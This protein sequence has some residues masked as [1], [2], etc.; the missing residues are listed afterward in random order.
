MKKYVLVGTGVRGIA[1]YIRPLIKDYTDCADLSAVYD[2]NEKR[3]HAAVKMEN[4]QNVKVYTDFDEMIK[5]EKPDTVII[6]TKDCTHD[7]YAIRAMELGCDVI[8][9]KPLTTDEN[10]FD[11]IY[12]CMKRTGKNVTVTFNMRFHPLY[13]FAKELMMKNVVGRVLSVHFEW[14]L[15][16]K[17]G[18][19]YFRRW[20][21]NRE[22][23]GSLIIHKATH[24]FDIINWLL[25]QHPVKVNA[26]GL[27]G[28]YGQENGGFD[29]VR[30][31]ECPK[32]DSC[33]YFFDI[34]NGEEHFRNLYKN[35]ESEDGYFR[36]R[37][38]FSE[39][40]DIE[41]TM[42]VN[43][44]YE[45][46]TVCSYSLTAHSPYEGNKFAL[47]GTDGRMEVTSMYNQ[48]IKKHEMY[49]KIFHRDGT[50]TT[51]T[52]FTRKTGEKD[53]EGGHGGADA[54]M[55]NMIFRGYRE[56]NLCQIA[57]VEDAAM[58]IGI[59]IAANKSLQQDRAV[60]IKDL[61][62]FTK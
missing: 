51:Y 16:T 54:E 41:D 28:F 26:F 42:S 1:S 2:I 57:G 45:K 14:M 17:H 55:R 7:F 44:L 33:K 29:G 8:S 4:A 58:S 60:Y 5:T 19:D 32:K 61:F 47:N 62:G 13:S 22:N 31:C 21:R 24:H 27:R 25:D 15:D 50:V 11:N 53:F 23:S 37:C 10:K 20:H 49:V 18:A 39:L 38:I 9:E 12:D 35:C 46:G 59:G 36:D 34:V 40:I 48:E 30:C 56:D 6:T 52:D 3:A 43:I